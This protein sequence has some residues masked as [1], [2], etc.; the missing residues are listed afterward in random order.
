MKARLYIKNTERMLCVVVRE[1]KFLEAPGQKERKITATS[2]RQCLKPSL[3]SDHDGSSLKMLRDSLLGMTDWYSKQCVLTWKEKITKSNRL[4]Y[5]LA[6]STRRTGGIGY[7]LLPTVVANDDNKSPE[8]HLAM[9]TRMKG[10]PRKTITSLQVKI[11]SL[12][13][14]PKA[15]NANASGPSRTGCREDLQTKVGKLRGKKLRLQPAM[16]EWMMGF[17]D[18]WTELPLAPQNTAENA[19]KRVGT[20]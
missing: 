7:G 11:K 10:G 16:T 18:G 20:Q 19:S 8:A 13:P 5:R 1:F 9:K 3:F 12:L 17:P 6:P 2:G 15:Q 4:L 14:T